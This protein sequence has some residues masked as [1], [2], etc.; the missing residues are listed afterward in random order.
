MINSGRTA[1]AILFVFS[2]AFTRSSL[3]EPPSASAS[4]SVPATQSSP[5]PF[6]GLQM[7]APQPVLTGLAELLTTLRNRAAERT[8]LYHC[9]PESWAV[10]DPSL[11][12]LGRMTAASYALGAGGA[13]LAIGRL[14]LRANGKPSGL[15]ALLRTLSVQPM[16]G[17]LG[18]SLSF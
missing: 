9:P 17:G 3:A 14:V 11:G 15:R 13:G 7:G 12:P 4:T 18:L 1:K 10:R 6:L 2:L 16:A 5:L 8:C